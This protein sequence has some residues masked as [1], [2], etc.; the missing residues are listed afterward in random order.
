MPRPSVKQLEYFVAV[1]RAGSFRRAADDLD[2]SQPTITAQIAQLEKQLGAQ[3]FE[4]GRSGATLSPAARDLLPQARKVLEEL[5]T[6]VENADSAVSGA[7]TYRLGVKSTLGPYVLP[8]ILP[9]IHQ[10]HQDLKLHVTEE[11]PSQLESNLENGELDLILTAF[12][13]NSSEIDGETLLR[14]DIKLVLPA[15]H[16][17][18]ERERLEGKDLEGLK[19][20]TTREGHRLTQLT[21]Q[22]A[23]RYGA[24]IQRD[25]Q[26]TSLDALRL[27]VVMDMGVALLP[28]L[29][30]HTEISSDSALEV[31][32]IGDESFARLIGLA[33]RQSSPAR[34]FFRQLA[35]DMRKAV[36]DNLG[37]VV[38]VMDDR[39]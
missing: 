38:S 19:L 29:Y 37:S 31:R 14:E 3:L 11:L 16:P 30:I 36:R 33:W 28:S 18:A 13:T 5:D 12:P 32:E 24:E 1:A 4:R 25:Y 9:S 8:R 39:R 21:E 35:R 7:A 15:G 6:L 27:M 22:I 23:T 2:I 20:L 17:L 10:Q 26:G 34:V